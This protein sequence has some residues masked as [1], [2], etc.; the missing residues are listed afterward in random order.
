MA[1]GQVHV[2]HSWL[3]GAG[4]LQPFVHSYVFFSFLHRRTLRSLPVHSVV[5]RAVAMR[6]V[7]L[8]IV[9]MSIV[10]LCFAAMHCSRCA[11]GGFFR[12]HCVLL[13]GVQ[14]SILRF[15]FASSI[16][17]CVLAPLFLRGHWSC[18]LILSISHFLQ[19]CWKLCNVV[20]HM[21]YI[22]SLPLQ[23]LE[24]CLYCRW[25]HREL[26]L[27]QWSVLVSMLCGRLDCVGE[28]SSVEHQG[29]STV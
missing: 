23:Q 12:L 21:S 16:V 15:L 29:T 26:H 17:H 3:I 14:F 28:A 8:R 7:A 4:C 9:A 11:L 18:V 10:A 27:G 22:W 19:F 1:L 24:L 25:S 5:F 20:L 2:D 6:S 13:L